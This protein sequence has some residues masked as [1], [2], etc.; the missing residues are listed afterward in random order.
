MP[1]LPSFVQFEDVRVVLITEAFTP[2]T[3][4]PFTE[5]SAMETD[6]VAD[7]RYAG[8]RADFFC[9]G[10]TMILTWAPIRDVPGGAPEPGEFTT[11][12]FGVL[13]DPEH[14]VNNA[15]AMPTSSSDRRCDASLTD[16]PH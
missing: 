8:F 10:G 15:S 1:A 9:A 13:G 16:I 7:E 4:L 6:C 2:V 3:A 12:P 5:D 11:G 14:A